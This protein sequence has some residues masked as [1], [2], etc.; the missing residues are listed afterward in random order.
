MTIHLDKSFA[1]LSILHVHPMTLRY[2]IYGGPNEMIIQEEQVTMVRRRVIH[3]KHGA[4]K[5]N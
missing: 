3:I 2:Q 1:K 4:R 5:A